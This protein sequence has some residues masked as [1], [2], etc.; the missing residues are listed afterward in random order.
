MQCKLPALDDPLVDQKLSELLD[1]KG[2]ECNPPKTTARMLDALVG[3]FLENAIIHPTFI[4][5]QPQI[6]S[7]LAKY[8][9]SKPHLTERFELFA[10]GREVRS[11]VFSPRKITRDKR[12]S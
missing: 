11:H 12:R 9:R 4:T 3:E 5:E 8:H 10:A 1:A 6:M 7:P 2:V